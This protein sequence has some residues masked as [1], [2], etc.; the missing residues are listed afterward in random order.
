M[1]EEALHASPESSMEQQGKESEDNVSN[2]GAGAGEKGVETSEQVRN[3]SAEAAQTWRDKLP[4]VVR[5]GADLVK[6]KVQPL[7]EHPYVAQ[8]A[9]TVQQGIRQTSA[10]IA[11]SA[12]AA[13]ARLQPIV[14][15][16]Y[17]QKSTGVLSSG[18]A[19]FKP[20]VVSTTDIVSSSLQPVVGKAA[21]TVQL[22][23]ETA[24]KI[25]YKEEGYESAK[26]LPYFA[27][28]LGILIFCILLAGLCT[29]QHRNP[30][31][32]PILTLCVF[33]NCSKS[34]QHLTFL[35][36]VAPGWSS[37]DGSSKYNVDVS[38]IVA[39]KIKLPNGRHFAYV[40]HGASKA[41]A[42]HNVL[43]VHGLMSSR[44]LGTS[45]SG[46]FSAMSRS[47]LAVIY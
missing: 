10:V 15:H 27:G 18:A 46:F 28:S 44:L 13:P 2:R 21:E 33:P 19:Q 11:Q 22:S 5:Q 24:K 42:K 26:I 4:E 7:M 14:N 36:G 47:L 16:P 31:H 12:A 1:E 25:Y 43:F 29:L 6:A 9:E 8:S 3:Q 34:S 39:D 41:D 35:H 32:C 40:E 23:K 20:L 38:N 17:V 37:S 45:S 30:R